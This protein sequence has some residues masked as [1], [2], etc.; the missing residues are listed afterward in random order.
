MRANGHDA[1]AEQGAG[2]L[3][4]PA[5]SVNV[6]PQEIATLALMFM[7]RVP[8]HASERVAFDRVEA[9]LQAIRSG[10]LVCIAPA[11]AASD[12]AARTSE[13]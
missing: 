7:Q 3:P 10:Q 1:A 11:P 6:N 13:A 4:A 12:A 5:V 8:F 2:L 9:V